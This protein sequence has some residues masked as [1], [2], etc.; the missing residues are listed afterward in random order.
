MS[1]KEKLQLGAALEIAPI[2]KVEGLITL[3]FQLNCYELCYPSK[4]DRELGEYV[5]RY[6]E[7]G[8]DPT[9]AY[10]D[11]EKLGQY[12]RACHASGVFTG[13]AYVFPN[14]LNGTPIYDGS[15]LAELNFFS[16]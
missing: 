1:P 15:N 10:L 11:L 9:L 4:D 3:I 5:A 13:G 6:L 7:Y 14:G 12:F 8:K 2:S 16:I